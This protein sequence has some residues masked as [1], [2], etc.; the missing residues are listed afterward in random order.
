MCVDHKNYS[1]MT[2]VTYITDNYILMDYLKARE[3]VIDLSQRA[4]VV[5]GTIVKGKYTYVEGT[6]VRPHKV[7]LG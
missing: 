3:A 6:T 2:Y 7:R 1:M 4:L 5:N